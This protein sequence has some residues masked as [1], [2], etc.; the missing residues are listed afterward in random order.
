MEMLSRQAERMGM[1]PLGWRLTRNVI[2]MS[3]QKMRRDGRP[4]T[5]IG[6]KRGGAGFERLPHGLGDR[7]DSRAKIADV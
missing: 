3:G 5:R 4:A 7:E 1:T 6:S 2:C